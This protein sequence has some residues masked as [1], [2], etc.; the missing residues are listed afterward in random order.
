ME[1][2][3]ALGGGSDDLFIESKSLI[4]RNQVPRGDSSVYMLTRARWPLAT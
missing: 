4:C 2:F 3:P 1:I